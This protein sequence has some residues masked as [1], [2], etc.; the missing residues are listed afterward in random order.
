MARRTLP[1]KILKFENFAIKVGLAH[2]CFLGGFWCGFRGGLGR[3]LKGFL[4]DLRSIWGLILVSLRIILM[5][6]LR[7]SKQNLLHDLERQ[8]P[9]RATKGKSM[10]GRTVGWMEGWMDG[11]DGW[12]DGCMDARMKQHLIICLAI[13][14]FYNRRLPLTSVDF[15]AVSMASS[16][17]LRFFSVFG[18]ISEDCGR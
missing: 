9:T 1:K 4:V 5:I 14:T 3:I 10:D 13:W 7:I 8:P 12:M 16:N 6:R 15:R 18:M 11:M 2:V 17:R